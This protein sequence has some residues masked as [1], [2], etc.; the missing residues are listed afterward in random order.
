MAWVDA[1][2]LPASGKGGGGV[3]GGLGS[4]LHGSKFW[5]WRSCT[6]CGPMLACGQSQVNDWQVITKKNGEETRK[7][8]LTIR[9]ASNR[10]IEITL[11]G[12]RAMDVG[13]NLE[14]VRVGWPWLDAGHVP[15]VAWSWV[16]FQDVAVKYDSQAAQGFSGLTLTLALTPPH[17][18]AFKEGRR[19]VLAVKA[20]RVGDFNGKT[21]STLNS[22]QC[23][24][25]PPIQQAQELRSWWVRCAACHR[26]GHRLG[27]GGFLG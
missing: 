4:G 27:G 1:S 10:S 2:M 13:G 17:H 5:S 6:F 11:W 24:M 20:A 15:T 18:Q 8:S 12:D 25:D 9:D 26:L 3:R 7:R 14:Q 16:V 21:L 19:P 22:S 23:L